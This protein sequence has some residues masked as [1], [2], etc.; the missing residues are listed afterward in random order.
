[1]TYF[2]FGAFNVLAAIHIIFMFPETAGRTL[3]EIEDV[4][5]QGHVFTAWRV[6]ASAGKKTLQD[7]KNKG[8]RTSFT[9]WR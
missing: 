4:F 3:E 1:V 6:D 5:S 7:V 8:V 9:C 2:I